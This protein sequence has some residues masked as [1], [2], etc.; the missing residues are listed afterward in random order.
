MRILL[1]GGAGYIG[2]HT[3]L[4]LLRTGHQVIIIDNYTN[5][6]PQVIHRLEKLTNTNIE[7]HTTDLANPET[8]LPI[9]NT[10]KYD[11]IIHFAGLKAVGESVAQP[12]RYYHTNLQSTLTI[13]ETL[14][15]QTSPHL[16]FSSSATVYGTPKHLPQTEKHPVGE[17]LT[18]PYGWSKYFNERIIED[19][20]KANPALTATMLR[21][22]NPIGA[23]HTG[24]IGEHP[25]GIPNNLLP[26]IAQV[27]VGHRNKLNIYGN[28]YNTP[29]GTGIRDYIHV[30]D[31]AEGHIAAL[32]KAPPGYSAY[33]LGTGV[34]SS[35]LQVLHEFEKASQKT[36]P[37]Q[38]CAPRPGDVAAIY[39]DPTLSKQQ[40]EWQTK[41]TLAD[42]C[43]D[44][45]NWQ[46]Q[47]P[48]GY[49][50]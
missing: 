24:Q 40:L 27:A 48:E 37:Y 47:N 44:T 13:L 19:E 5:S 17:N 30:T 42:A 10:L 3:A 7:T 50:T 14:R 39:A 46:K 21:Y 22:Y 43:R 36:I 1:T 32:K 38:I 11:A 2:S 34:G 28:T 9:L 6:S 4:A 49:T 35:V 25:N 20:T 12:A 26:Y 33:N 15:T 16:I 23:D 8:S 18:N 31:L 41:H 45:W 29:D